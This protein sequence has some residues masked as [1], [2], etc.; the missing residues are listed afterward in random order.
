MNSHPYSHLIR[1][2]QWADRGLYEVVLRHIDRLQT[3]DAA[4][5]LRILDHIHVVDLIFQH[6]LEGLPHAF[7]APRSGKTL[8][9]CKLTEDARQ[10]DDWYVSYV[11]ERSAPDFERSVDFVF[12]NNTRGRMTCGEILLHVALHGTY[13]RGNAGIVLQRNGVT[14]NDDRMTDFLERAA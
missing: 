13:H 11:N 12:T 14:P 7:Q 1:Y 3:E 9:L 2:K 8:D 4:I 6:H 5:L 10:V